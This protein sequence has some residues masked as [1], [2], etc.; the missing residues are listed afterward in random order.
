MKRAVKRAWDSITPEELKPIIA[1]FRLRLELCVQEKGGHFEHL[2]K[3]EKADR[4]KEQAER[5]RRAELAKR[6]LRERLILKLQQGRSRRSEGKKKVS[7]LVAPP[8][9]VPV[10]VWE[11]VSRLVAPPATVPVPV[12]ENVSRLVAPPPPPPTE[13]AGG[14]IGYDLVEEAVAIV[15]QWTFDDELPVATDPN[16]LVGLLEEIEEM[17]Q[18]WWVQ[19]SKDK[20]TFN[21]QDLAKK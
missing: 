4:V 9:T 2:I 21:I 16:D 8:A 12:W 14:E 15:E 17:G 3:K 7:R 19:W 18:Q 1:E 5:M 11:N 13:Q 6:E 10:P 20:K